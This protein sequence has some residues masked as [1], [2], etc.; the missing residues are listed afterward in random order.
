MIHISCSV[1]CDIGRAD[2]DAGS[3]CPLQKDAD[4]AVVVAVTSHS[5]FEPGADEDE[6]YGE[7]VAF[8][9]LQVVRD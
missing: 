9:L 6:V 8:P 2:E 5:V 3:V 4:R 7:G 1:I